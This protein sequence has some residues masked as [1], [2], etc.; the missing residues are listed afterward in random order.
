MEK[1]ANE[2][3]YYLYISVNISQVFKLRRMKWAGHVSRMM[4]WKYI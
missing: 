2:E 1:N 3:L 4:E